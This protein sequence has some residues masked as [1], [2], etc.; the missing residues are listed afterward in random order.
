MDKIFYLTFDGAVNPPNTMRILDILKEYGVKATFFVEGH[1]ISGHED[2]LKRILSEGHHIGN[3]SF[4]HPDFSEISPEECMDE[5]LSTD[6]ALKEACGLH[7][8]LMRPPCGVLPEDRKKMIRDAGYI[9][10]LWSISVKDWLGPDAPSIAGRVIELSRDEEV[11]A[12]LHDHVDWNPDVLP[13]IIPALKEKG[14][15]FEPL[16][17]D[18]KIYPKD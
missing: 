16:P 15:R 17:Y 10:S 9:V 12:V 18:R 14:Y 1:R 3:H 8:A 6:E 11:V 13:L 5:I 7:T 4:H 2:T